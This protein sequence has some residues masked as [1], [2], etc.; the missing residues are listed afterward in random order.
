MLNQLDYDIPREVN[1]NISMDSIA[2]FQ[3]RSWGINIIFWAN[4][5]EKV[6]V[7]SKKP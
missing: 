4:E 6:D 2:R 1:P 3:V 5:F 7:E